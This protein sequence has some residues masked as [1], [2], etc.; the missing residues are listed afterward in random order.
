MAAGNY[1]V[2]DLV[3]GDGGFVR[4]KGFSKHRPESFWRGV[5]VEYEA[6]SLGAKDFCYSRGLAQSTFHKWRLRLSPPTAPPQKIQAKS[7][8][9]NSQFL[10]IYLATTVTPPQQS[11]AEKPCKLQAPTDAAAESSGLIVHVAESL[12][13]VIAKDFHAPTLRRLVQILSSKAPSPC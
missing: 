4:G 9:N 11:T 2:M 6:S 7:A 12:S 13:I 1:M 8:V 10:P 5:M 3:D